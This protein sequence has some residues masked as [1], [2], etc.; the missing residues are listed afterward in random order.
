VGR[1][2]TWIEVADVFSDREF[3]YTDK[4]FNVVKKLVSEQTGIHLTDAKKDLVYGRLSKRIRRLGLSSFRE[5]IEYVKQDHEQELIN[6]INAITTNLTSFFRENH[7][8]EYLGNTLLPRIVET[9]DDTRKIR[10]W[11]AGCSTGEEPYSIAMAILEKLSSPNWDVKILA[12]DLD[13]NVIQ[14]GKNGVYPI[15]KIVGLDK[16]RKQRWFLNGSGKN[17]GKVKVSSELQ[18]MITFKQLNLMN[19]W[20]MQGK[21]DAIFCRNV[22]IYFDKPTQKILFDRFANIM[23]DSGTLFI[24]HSETLFKVSTRFKAIGNTIYQKL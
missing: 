9:N 3:H 20:P 5:Y 21:F 13:T 7:H 24:G 8:F 19:T 15:E 1:V 14:T 4:D 18:E 12:T 17:L 16:E 6:F 22:V 10:I 2:L 11:S 23:A